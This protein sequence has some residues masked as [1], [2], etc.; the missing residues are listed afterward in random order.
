MPLSEHRTKKTK[1]Y[2]RPKAFKKKQKE[3]KKEIQDHFIATLKREGGK[4]G[5]LSSRFVN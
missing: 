5:E 4:E 3:K 2:S 1:I